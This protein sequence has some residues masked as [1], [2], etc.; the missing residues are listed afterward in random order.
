MSELAGQTRSFWKWTTGMF[1]KVVL[2][3][4]TAVHTLYLARLDSPDLL[5]NSPDDWSGLQSDVSDTLFLSG[6]PNLGPS[7]SK[8]D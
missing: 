4:I 2:K 6:I 1:L 3:P 5:W 8:V 7:C